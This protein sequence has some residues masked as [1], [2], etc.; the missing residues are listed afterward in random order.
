MEWT[1]TFR[2]DAPIA[3]VFDYLMDFGRVPL[4]EVLDVKYDRLET[5]GKFTA[6]LKQK[7]QVIRSRGEFLEVKRPFVM[8]A[9]SHCSGY[10]TEIDLQLTPVE[11]ATEVKVIQRFMSPDPFYALFI[12]QMNAQWELI[13]GEY[14]EE[15]ERA[16]QANPELEWM[17]KAEDQFEHDAMDHQWQSFFS[18]RPLQWIFLVLAVLSGVNLYLGFNGWM[19]AGM[20][21]CLGYFW[22]PYPSFLVLILITGVARLLLFN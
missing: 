9:R 4:A 18:K 8:K 19:L 22:R 5:E 10:A 16:Y 2:I 20:L 13:W 15:I 12:S 21:F 3:Y 6:I 11:E 1:K 17:T 14:Q 7:G